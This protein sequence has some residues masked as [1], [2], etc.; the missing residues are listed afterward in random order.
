MPAALA[1]FVKQV[2]A[3]PGAISVS[4]D[5]MVL[6]SAYSGIPVNYWVTVTSAAGT[7][8]LDVPIAQAVDNTEE[9]FGYSFTAISPDPALAAR[10]GGDASFTLA[11]KLLDYDPS[12]ETRD[13][14][15]QA[16]ARAGKP[17]VLTTAPKP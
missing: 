14:V 5:S 13:A 12:P 10:Y 16:V 17:G 6:G 2:I 15:Q 8:V 11:G 1:A 4:L 7:T 3:A 9:S